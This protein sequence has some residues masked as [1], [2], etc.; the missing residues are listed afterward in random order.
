MATAGRSATVPPR[1]PWLPHVV[2]PAAFCKMRRSMA[3]G[4]AFARSLLAGRRVPV[5]AVAFA[6]IAVAT[7]AV[8]APFL[9]HGMTF[10]D[11]SWFFHFGRRALQGD[12]PYRDYVFQVGPLPIYVDALF[13]KLFGGTYLVSLYAA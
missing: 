6:A 11:A 4:R 13:Q 8:R 1:P 2:K 7:I 10:S 3:G 12:V 9:H 5:D